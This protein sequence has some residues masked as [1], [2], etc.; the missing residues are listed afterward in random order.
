M[1]PYLQMTN[2]KALITMSQL[3]HT[4]S[5]SWASHMFQCPQTHVAFHLSSLSSFTVHWWFY[6]PK[7]DNLHF[8]I[9]DP[10]VV[11]SL[12]ML[13]LLKKCFENIHFINIYEFTVIFTHMC[14]VYNLHIHPAIFHPCPT[15]CH[16]YMF[17]SSYQLL[18]YFPVRASCFYVWER[19]YHAFFLC[20][21]YFV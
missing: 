11:C 4:S 1:L 9:R 19:I 3:C 14:T 10:V 15:S 17:P 13:Y 18:P 21:V 2:W 16:P 8:R 20:W 7:E 6:L 12:D 5:S